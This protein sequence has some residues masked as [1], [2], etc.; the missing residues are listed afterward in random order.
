[1]HHQ[2]TREAV[3]IFYDDRS[4]AVGGYCSRHPR[5]M[6]SD[7]PPRGKQVG[8]RMVPLGKFA[9]RFHIGW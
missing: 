3:C 7:D 1:L 9:F 4:R 6:A 5:H 8:L 2:V